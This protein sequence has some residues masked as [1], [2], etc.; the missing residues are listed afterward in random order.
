MRSG[1][2]KAWL[3][4]VLALT[5]MATVAVVVPW[6]LPELRTGDVDPLGALIGVVSLVV[7]A[8]SLVLA[9]RALRPPAPSML[10]VAAELAHAVKRAETAARRQL[11][12]GDDT[13]IDVTFT[14]RPAP[15]HTPPARATIGAR[16]GGRLGQVV[17]YYRELTPGRMVIT[18]APGAGKT[19]LAVELI[20]GLIE[21]RAEQDAVPLRISATALDTAVTT[22]SAVDAWLVRHLTGVYRLRRDTAVALVDARLVTPV[23]DGLDEMDP[24]DEP[25]YDSRAGRALR[26]LNAYQDGRAK[27]AVVLTCRSTH[28]QALERARVW[29]GSPARVELSPVSS[30]Q[31]RA[32][33]SERVTDLS[34]WEPVLRAIGH[35][36]AGPL[37]EGLSTPWRLTLAAVVHEQRTP[38]GEFVRDPA[39]LTGAALGTAQAVRDHLL[40]SF[41]P[42]TVASRTPP[43]EAG[44]DRVHR[45]LAVL[46]R[47]LD[48]N[49]ATGRALGG[50]ALSGTDLVLHE[51]WPLA[52]TLRPRMITAAAVAVLG[53]AVPAQFPDG[54][55]PAQFVIAG[56]SI[57]GVLILMWQAW[58]ITWPQPSRFDLSRLRSR[59]GRRTLAVRL[60]IGLAIGIASGL[61]AG[62]ASGLV[63]TL[64]DRRT[65]GLGTALTFGLA[66]GLGT[67]LAL[68]LA[69]GLVA[70]GAGG[71]ADPRDGVRTDLVAGVTLALGLQVAAALALEVAVVVVAGLATAVA[72]GLAFGLAGLRYVAMLL[73]ARRW[74][75]V[76]LPWRL[77]RFLDWAHG[78]GLMRVAGVAYQF[79][80]R[81]LQDYLAAH[82]V[83]ER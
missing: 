52:G 65:D 81:E 55:S 72:F 29:A 71:T 75:A 37:A 49:S 48:T 18:G 9:A 73:C 80:H 63:A 66:G 82:P 4:G 40:A 5:G 1:R 51:L 76:W 16:A 6:F 67:G 22:A 60:A 35:A 56:L 83:P 50:R 30:R 45:W 47:Y 70:S 42:A 43:G 38:T 44:A 34:R 28:Y 64:A 25:G 77:G 46:A 27:A 8:V 3:W 74:N 33:L 10:E 58:W 19:V 15:C 11:L 53:A 61:A 69:F 62:L 57:A 21:D 14:L 41:I 54:L 26:A 79:R 24:E 2:A 68:G 13:V 12:G 7:A 17:D 36:P 31:A 23:I 39:D 20:L 78:A 59:T 32:F